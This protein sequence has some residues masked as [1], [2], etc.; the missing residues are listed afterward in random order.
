MAQEW[1]DDKGVKWKLKLDECV[2]GMGFIYQNELLYQVGP[3]INIIRK[4]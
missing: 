2:F 3:K 4:H 1:K